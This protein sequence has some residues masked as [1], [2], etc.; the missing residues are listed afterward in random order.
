[1]VALVERCLSPAPEDRY[2]HARALQ[3]AITEEAGEAEKPADSDSLARFLEQLFPAQMARRPRLTTAEMTAQSAPQDNSAQHPA[4]QDDT[5]PANTPYDPSQTLSEELPTA[6]HTLELGDWATAS[7]QAA[8]GSSPTNSEQATYSKTAAQE[9]EDLR[10]STSAEHMAIT[11]A[12]FQTSLAD[13]RRIRLVGRPDAVPP[14]P[15]SSSSTAAQ[16]LGQSTRPIDPQADP[17]QLGSLR[18]SDEEQLAAAA[19]LTSAAQPGPP[20]TDNPL[21]PGTE[22]VKPLTSEDPPRLRRW[23]L[24]FLAAFAVLGLVALIGGPS[25]E[26]ATEL[27]P[28]KTPEEAD[29]SAA[30]TEPSG[31]D[32]P[33]QLGTLIINSHPWAYVSVD[34]V[35]REWVTPT[36][37]ELAAGPHVIGLAHPASDWR[38]ERTVTVVAG[39]ELTLSVNR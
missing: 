2:P 38:I 32:A 7:G 13:P 5:A 9:A 4:A 6:L 8:A 26:L 29:G 22:A 17:F 28:A 18:E 36:R 34:G 15:A 33:V 1:L 20:D 16:G 12:D 21:A 25:T 30:S 23:L 3:E 37:L 24:P 31:E 27:L 19:A 39:K 11:T 10:A 14:A 35:L